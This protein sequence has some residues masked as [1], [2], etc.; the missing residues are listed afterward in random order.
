MPS[1]GNWTI[2]VFDTAGFDT[3]TLDGWSVHMEG[4]AGPGPCEGVF[5]GACCDG[6]TGVCTDDV[7]EANCVGDQLEW[8]K[9]TSCTAISCVQHTGACC[10]GNTGLCVND[11][12]PGDCVGDQQ[13]WSKGTSCS[14]IVC[15][16]HTG[17]CCDGN[18]GLCADD[19]LPGDCVGDQQSWSK[20]TACS[21][22]NCVQHTGACCDG[23]TGICTDDVLPGDCI[24]AFETWTKGASCASVVCEPAPVTDIPT[25][26]AWGVAIL[27]LLL[28]V[29]AKVYFRPG[30]D[31]AGA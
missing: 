7:A 17:A 16:Q 31:P 12:L 19:V 1:A 3:G 2:T 25:V 28:L 6:N 23:V 4:P 30:K 13:S 21:A 8:Y 20:D 24:A 5:P 29:L 22:V 15:E 14:A 9:N 26:S 11:V 27:A 18:T 10:D